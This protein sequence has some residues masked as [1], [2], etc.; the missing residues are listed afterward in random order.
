MILQDNETRAVL[1]RIR[2]SPQKLNLVASMIR[3]KHAK[4]AMDILLFSNK[5]I[6][7]DVRKTLQSAMANAQNNKGLDPD[8]L[9]VKESFVGSSIKLR[10]FMPRGR[11]RSSSISK[12]FSHLTIVVEERKV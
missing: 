4:R 7:V 5:R 3:G 6:A 11:G 9:Y 8:K 12:P 10:R 1:K 2:V